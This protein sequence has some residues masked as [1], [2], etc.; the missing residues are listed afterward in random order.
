MEKTTPFIYPAIAL[1][2]IIIVAQIGLIPTVCL[3]IALWVFIF[4]DNRYGIISQRFNKETEQ[5]IR[6]GE[7][8]RKDAIEHWAKTQTNL[9]IG[10]RELTELVEYM[11]RV[12]D[13]WHVEECKPSLLAMLFKK[14]V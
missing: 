7:C 5:A 2:G 13:T 9:Y 4:L 10:E 12:R 14:F 3:G 8:S 1:V 11:Y 6:R